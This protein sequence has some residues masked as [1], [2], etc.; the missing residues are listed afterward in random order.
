MFYR[1][2]MFYRSRQRAR[3]RGSEANIGAIAK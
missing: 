3:R 1:G 2:V